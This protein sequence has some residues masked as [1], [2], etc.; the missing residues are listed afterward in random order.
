MA[1]QPPSGWGQPP[2]G[3][4]PETPSPGTSP[5][6]TPIRD[7]THAA[8]TG[9]RTHGRARTSGPGLSDLANKSVDVLMDG[10]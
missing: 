5:M 1:A 2:P 6:W 8:R 10:P 9:T 4:V 7:A 3:H